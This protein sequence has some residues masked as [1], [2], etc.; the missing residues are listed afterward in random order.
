VRCLAC[1]GRLVALW[2][3][4][5]REPEHGTE[6]LDVG[7]SKVGRGCDGKVLTAFAGLGRG[8]GS[9]E[10]RRRAK[11]EW[12]RRLEMEKRSGVRGCYSGG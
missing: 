10:Q 9:E 4:R 6:G 7:S 12:R 8:Y 5:D 3:H 2:R 11:M 1:H